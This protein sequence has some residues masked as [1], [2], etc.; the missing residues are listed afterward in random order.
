[1]SNTATLT[2]A[3]MKYGN[4]D[5]LEEQLKNLVIVYENLPEQL[6]TNFDVFVSDNN[7]GDG[8][9]L[10]LEN[11]SNLYPWISYVIQPSYI[12]YDEHVLFLY[13]TAQGDYIWLC[14]VDDFIKPVEAIQEV[15]NVIKD[16]S[17]TGAIVEISSDQRNVQNV[18]ERNFDGPSSSANIDSKFWK[19]F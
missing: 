2:V 13:N 8:S 5:A 17:V 15:F 16:K 10:I 6:K 7:S 12:S 4:L 19:G 9:Q 11:Y 14:A 1:M 18:D 3:I